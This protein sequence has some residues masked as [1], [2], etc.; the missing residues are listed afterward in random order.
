MGRVH[1]LGGVPCPGSIFRKSWSA[2]T[3][4]A[5]ATSVVASARGNWDAPAR[6]SPTFAYVYFIDNAYRNPPVVPSPRRNKVPVRASARRKG[7]CAVFFVPADFIAHSAPRDGILEISVGERN[8]YRVRRR[9]ET[10]ITGYEINL[11]RY[12]V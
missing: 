3:A 4:A 7:G 1:S 10:R 6:E 5:A 2:A 8:R 9:R 12:A 11:F